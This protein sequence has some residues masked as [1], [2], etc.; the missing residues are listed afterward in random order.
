MHN[1]VHLRRMHTGSEP[2]FAQIF[3]DLANPTYRKLNQQ[4]QAQYQI[5][6]FEEFAKD[7]AAI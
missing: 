7:L 4:V 1:A 2:R 6:S 3:K 5:K